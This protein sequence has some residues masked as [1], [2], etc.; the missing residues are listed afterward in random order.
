V[1]QSLSRAE[2][3]THRCDDERRARFETFQVR[4]EVAEFDPQFEAFRLSAVGRFAAST[5]K[6]DRQ[7]EKR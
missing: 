3:E 6:H 2:Q 4:N 1:R 5:P 7:R